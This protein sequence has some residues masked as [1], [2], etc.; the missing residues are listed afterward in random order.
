MR[1]VAITQFSP[2]ALPPGCAPIARSRFYVHTPWP[3]VS[4]ERAWQAIRPVSPRQRDSR[5][6]GCCQM[7]ES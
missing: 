4:R 1:D 3:A 5:Q 6:T 2:A 7:I